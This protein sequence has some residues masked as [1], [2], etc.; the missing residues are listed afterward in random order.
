[1]IDMPDRPLDPPEEPVAKEP[2]PDWE[3]DAEVQHVIDMRREF[4]RCVTDDVIA[5]IM[6]IGGESRS[7]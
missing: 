7:K 2:D 1:M 6:E 4:A 5:T 3:H